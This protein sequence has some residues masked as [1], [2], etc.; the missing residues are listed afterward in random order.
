[1]SV[2]IVKSISENP[3]EFDNPQDFIKY[4]ELN[5]NELSKFSTCALNKKFKIKGFHIG[6]KKGEVKLI[7][8]N[9]H[10]ISEYEQHQQ[11]ETI[12]LKLD[13]IY[14]SINKISEKINLLQNDLTKLLNALSLN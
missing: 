13:S 3:T 11:D 2:E 14:A 9:L 8:L 5:K 1:M 6:R 12:D 4:Y 10:R 7:P